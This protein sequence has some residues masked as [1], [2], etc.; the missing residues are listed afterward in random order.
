MVPD[1]DPQRP[2]APAPGSAAEG[3]VP[4][5]LLPLGSDS[6]S[7]RGL[8]WVFFGN[9]GLRAGWSVAVFLTLNS[10]CARIVSRVF[11]TFIPDLW[12]APLSLDVVLL[13]EMIPF[14]GILAAAAIVARI[15]HRNILAFNLTG[16]RRMLYFLSG[17]AA[18]LAA[19]SALMGAIAWSGWL[20]FGPIALSGTGIF[21]AGAIWAVALLFLGC[22]EEGEFRCYLQFTLTRGINFWWALGIVAVLLLYAMFRVTDPGVR[23]V[24]VIALLGLVPCLLLHVNKRQGSGFWQACWVTSTLFGFGHIGNGGSWIYI[25]AMGAFGFLLCVSVRVTGSAWWAIGCHTSWNWADIFVFGTL[26]GHSPAPGHLLTTSTIGSSVWSGG[27]MYPEGSPLV[28]GVLLLLLIVLLVFHGRKKSTALR[29][30]ATNQ[31]T[32]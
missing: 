4:R 25:L 6:R 2:G 32:A 3:P 11:V 5:Q 17:L 8:K 23:G 7:V 13:R 19:V 9:Q 31:S 22:T 18:G 29:A 27:T 26:Y 10:I 30:H 20:H 12:K 16:P 1:I 24:H 21:K 15:E 14:L 28:F